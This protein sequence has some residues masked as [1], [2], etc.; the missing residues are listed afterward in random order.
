MQVL[1]AC[2]IVLGAQHSPDAVIGWPGWHT[3]TMQP[4]CSGWVPLLHRH[5]PLGP[6]GA[7]PDGQALMAAPTPA[8]I[9]KKISA[10]AKTHV[11]EID[12]FRSRRLDA[13]RRAGQAII[14]PIMQP[15]ASSTPEERGSVPRRAVDRGRMPDRSFD[16][17]SAR[18]VGHHDRPEHPQRHMARPSNRGA[19]AVAER[20]RESANDRSIRLHRQIFAPTLIVGLGLRPCFRRHANMVLRSG[21]APEITSHAQTIGKRARRRGGIVGDGLIMHGAGDA[22]AIAGERVAAHQAVGAAIGVGELPLNRRRHLPGVLHRRIGRAPAAPQR[23][24]T[25]R[26]AA[27]ERG[28]LTARA[29]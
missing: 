27:P 24:M 4:P 17:S 1:S 18:P 22:D 25:G 11:P 6:V 16:C 12:R 14:H 3:S 8:T 23:G 5:A 29:A 19:A 7:W 13:H 2:G 10:A 9:Q 15:L 28:H 20:R 21:P 26:T